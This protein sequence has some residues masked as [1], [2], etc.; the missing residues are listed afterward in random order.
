MR[1]AWLHARAAAAEKPH[2]NGRVRLA[3]VET[4]SKNY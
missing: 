2:K 1:L 3:R 4:D